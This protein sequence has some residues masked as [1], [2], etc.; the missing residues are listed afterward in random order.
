MEKI[1]Y[2][3]HATLRMFERKISETDVANVLKSGTTIENYPDDE[4]YPSFLKLGFS[5]NR[6]IHVVVANNFTEQTLVVI[7]V[8]EPDP[9]KW[10][11]GFTKRKKI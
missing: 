3:F 7:T 1:I 6:P 2:R 8:Y 10:E 11:L 5:G 4:P 9:L